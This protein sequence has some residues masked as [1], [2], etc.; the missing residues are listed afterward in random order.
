MGLENLQ[1]RLGSI[2]AELSRAQDSQRATEEKL[3]KTEN[4]VQKA[5]QKTTQISSE[6]RTFST[7]VTSRLAPFSSLRF[8]DL[9]KAGFEDCFTVR[10]D[11]FLAQTDS[12]ISKGL[13]TID[14]LSHERD[15]KKSIVTQLLR[16]V[17]NMKREIERSVE[18]L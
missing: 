15:E 8:C 9:Y 7:D 16:E 17:E 3:S 12:M 4:A 2:A 11:D 1:A 6:M 18:S 13:S 10:K 5:L 14:K